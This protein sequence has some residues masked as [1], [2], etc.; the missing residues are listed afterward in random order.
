V[1]PQQMLPRGVQRPMPYGARVPGAPAPGPGYPMPGYGMP[2]QQQRGQPRRGRQGPG[3]AGPQGAPQ[4][5]RNFKYTANARNHPRDMAPGAV[6]PPAAPAQVAGVPQLEPLTSA[7]LAAASPEIQKNMIGE[8]LYPL[9]HRQQPELAGKITG[10]LLEMD[11]GELL[12]LLE[13]PDAL[14]AKIQEAIQVL[15]AAQQS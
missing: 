12:H 8:R 14:E 4:N 10:M 3:P 2:M 15:E 7:A 13:S 1:Y 11:N 9:I 5:R 6:M